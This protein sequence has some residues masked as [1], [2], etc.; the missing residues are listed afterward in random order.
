MGRW[1][2]GKMGRRG[3]GKTR[4]SDPKSKI[5]PTPTPSPEG[6]RTLQNPKSKI[7]NPQIL[8]LAFQGDAGRWTCLAQTDDEAQQVVFYSLCPI[9]VVDEHYGAI[10]ELILRVNEG[11][12]IGNF[13]FDV[14]QGDIRYKTSLDT[15]GDRLTPALMRRLVYANVHTM[16]TYLPGIIAVLSGNCS[17]VEAI[18][19]IEQT[20]SEF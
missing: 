15:E 20:T 9:S 12:I 11:L 13:E 16:D 7:Q 17:P 1:E 5:P 14:D 6:D 8:Q 2:D 19:A 18:A 4:K 3:D 10:A